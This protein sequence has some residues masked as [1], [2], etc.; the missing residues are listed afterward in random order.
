MLRHWGVRVID[1]VNGSELGRCTCRR[2]FHHLYAVRWRQ[3][4]C[5][6]VRAQRNPLQLLFSRGMFT[7]KVK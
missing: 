1:M 2:A 3:A 6:N 5:D 7:I 4:H